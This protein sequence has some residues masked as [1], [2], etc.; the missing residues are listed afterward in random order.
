MQFVAKAYRDLEKDELYEI[1][2]SRAQVFVV[3]G[4]IRYLDMDGIDRR[5]LHCFLTDGDAVLAYLRAFPTEREGEI[6]IGRVLTRTHGL[7]HGRR[8]MEQAMRAI[9]SHFSPARLVLHAQTP[10]VGFYEKL[11][12][13]VTSDEFLEAGIPHVKMEREV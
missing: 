8:L 1:L 12:F 5:S 7:G 9:C 10:V 2:L 4:N 6:K 13:A 11:G 3:E